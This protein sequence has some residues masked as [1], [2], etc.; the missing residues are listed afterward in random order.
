MTDTKTIP[1]ATTTTLAADA[2]AEALATVSPAKIRANRANAALSTGPR[3]PEGKRI[4][5]WNAMRHGVLSTAMVLADESEADFRALRDHLRADLAPVG[6]VEELLTD[7]IVSLAWRL[8]RLGR[9][10]GEILRWAKAEAD[11]IRHHGLSRKEWE[12]EKKRAEA[13]LKGERR[14]FKYQDVYSESGRKRRKPV[15]RWGFHPVPAVDS[16]DFSLE[17]SGAARMSKTTEGKEGE[18]NFTEAYKCLR[19]GAIKAADEQEKADKCARYERD[20]DETALGR[21]FMLESTDKALDK[22]TRYETTTDR[23]LHRT[24]EQLLQL[25]ASRGAGGVVLDAEAERHGTE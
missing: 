17:V 23:A 16:L 15:E 12:D 9:V 11:R 4:T 5:R 10:E 3:S 14:T 18:D 21:G 2:H 13:A 6:A 8:R 20:A 7:R 22:L 24:L 19:Y 1:N 25:Q